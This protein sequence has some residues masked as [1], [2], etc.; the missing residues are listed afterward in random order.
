MEAMRRFWR[1][2]FT[3]LIFFAAGAAVGFY[4]RDQQQHKKIQEAVEDARQ[5][6]QQRAERAREGI[7]AGA[8]AAADSTRAAVREMLGDSAN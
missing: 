5:E 4:V 8:R 3:W 1:R 2:L 6:M 7:E